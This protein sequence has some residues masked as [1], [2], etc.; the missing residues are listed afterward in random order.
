MGVLTAIRFDKNFKLFFER[1]NAKG[2]HTAAA[3][4]A[5]MKKMI[6]I[7]HALYKNDAVYDK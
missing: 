1:L 2:K 6:L 3:Q 5:V 7:A 4:I